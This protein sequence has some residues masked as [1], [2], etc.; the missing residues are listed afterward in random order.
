MNKRTKW[1]RFRI[2]TILIFFLLSF[3]III[4][5]DFQIQIIN[6]NDLETRARSQHLKKIDLLPER[7]SVYDRNLNE[8]AVSID[9]DSVYAHPAKVVKPRTLARTIA[10]VLS[11]GQMRIEGKL[12][13]DSSFVW[14]KRQIDL[15]EGERK[16]IS[17]FKGIG[18]MKEGKRFYPPPN[19]ASNVIGFV[20]LDSRGLEG[21][22]LEYNR[23]L[24]GGGVRV[25]GERD[26]LGREM[27]FGD[28]EKTYPIKGNDVVLTIDKT[29]QYITDKELRK[30]VE[31]TEAKA[32]MAIVMDPNTGEILAMAN[33]PTFD[34]N[35]F[36]DYRP[37]EWRNRS[38][39]D[40]YEPGS[41][42]K[43]FLVAAALEEGLVRPNDIFYCENGKYQVAD[44][45]FHDVKEHGWL[46]VANIIKYSSN[47]GAIKLGEKL[48]GER[49]VR[50]INN[51]GFG[52]NT[53][54]DIP[55]E[56][57]GVI[58]RLERSKVSLATASFGHG[59]STTAIQ[60]VTGISAI[61]NGGFLY[62][63]YIVSSI[64]SSDGKMVK[65]FN[66]TVVRRVIS[67]E[68]ALMVKKI[69]EGVTEEG[70]T[71]EKASFAGMK[72]AGKTG[73]AQKPDL[74][75]GGYAPG[76]Y[77]SSFFG[78]APADSPRLAVLVLIDEPAGDFYGSTIAAP[79]F[80]EIVKQ[81]MAYLG[82]FP[83]RKL[84]TAKIMIPADNGM[85]HT[86]IKKGK[87]PDF[88]D[89]SMRMVLRI[90]NEIP[91]ELEVMGSGRAVFQ[92]P[93][94]GSE[95]VPDSVVKVRFQ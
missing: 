21:I 3:I 74:V 29:I 10:P 11:T 40:N 68:T 54:I 79:V 91:I 7:G 51:F 9:V 50:Y 26:A 18:L 62:K 32:G 30:A 12:L 76:K 15:A 42:F 56:A 23:Y 25:Y 86:E 47:I 70:G 38:I 77:I 92:R 46:S 48:G 58:K 36:W 27:L 16:R 64:V 37:Q 85:E 4:A 28:L 35:K 17:G 87:M 49:Y 53:G 61:A 80:R 8:L 93:L 24:I 90:A 72:V 39:T 63:P 43:V 89:K 52:K 71:G 5:R 34:P 31:V 6:N 75:N 78:F 13:S 60:L 45:L 88:R 67:D 19:L 57:S 95:I 59:I 33:L 84:D 22:E 73:T 1:L 2:I 14:L 66:P 20:G 94:P 81:S 44:R 82:L 83:E 55:G 41:I 69:L 65:E